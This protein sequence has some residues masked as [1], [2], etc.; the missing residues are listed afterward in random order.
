MADGSEQQAQMSA[1]LKE[2][3]A[4]ARRELASLCPEDGRPAGQAGASPLDQS[5]GR[6]LRD[7]RTVALLEKYSDMLL[8]IAEKKMD[9][10]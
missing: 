4:E 8:Q 5:P 10:H 3:F 7:E 6:Q 2:A 1:V 9:C